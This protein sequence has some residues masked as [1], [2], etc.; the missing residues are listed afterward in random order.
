MKKRVTSGVVIALVTI[1]SILAGGILLKAVCFL[2][3][4]Y[5]AYE[6]VKC[7]RNDFDLLTYLLTASTI[8]LIYFDFDRATLYLILDAF[9]LFIV[10][11]F[12]KKREIDDLAVM[13]LM[14]LIIGSSIYFYVYT[15]EINKW[16]LGYAF[17]VAF[18]TDL[19]AFFVGTR[20]GTHKLNE[21][22]SPNKSIEGAIGGVVLGSLA[23]ILYA[24]IFRFFGLQKS[25]V[26]IMSILL[27]IISQI[28]DLAY[29]LLKRYYGIKDFSNLI[30]G[31]G[32]LLDRLDSVS[33]TICIIGIILKFVG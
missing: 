33:F 24:L 16:I 6:L 1:C 12:D 14:T 8:L 23:S 30:P 13:L 5:G 29:S 7:V 17:V 19:F 11:I 20:F 2:I 21:R 32:G 25:L 3:G 18:L 26:I 15:S 27:P 9:S 28:G 4:L 22:V 31:H 10:S